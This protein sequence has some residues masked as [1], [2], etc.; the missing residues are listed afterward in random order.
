MAKLVAAAQSSNV[1]DPLGAAVDQFYQAAELLPHS[2]EIVNLIG[3][4]ESLSMLCGHSKC[5]QR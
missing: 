5:A 1:A 4:A 2:A 3:A